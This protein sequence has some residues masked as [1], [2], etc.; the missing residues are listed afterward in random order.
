MRTLLTR[1]TQETFTVSAA[2]IIT[3]EK[4]EVLLLNHV[5]R[6]A[7]GWGIPGGFLDA[8]EQ[9]EAA[10]RREIREEAGIDLMDV[11]I[12]RAN[13]LRRHIEILFTAKGIGEARVGSREITELGWFAP[14]DLPPEMNIRQQFLIRRALG[15]E[16]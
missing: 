15:K 8:N 3:N 7:S 12:Y 2:G 6:P 9:P 13:T 5:L 1:G 14:D 11:R 16:D 4:N 10:F